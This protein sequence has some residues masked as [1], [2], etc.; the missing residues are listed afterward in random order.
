[1]TGDDLVWFMKH[2]DRQ[3]RVREAIDDERLPC[4]PGVR[5]L[6]VVGRTGAAHRF[7]ASPS[8]CCPSS[9]FGLLK[10]V[11]EIM[12]HASGR[13]RKDFAAGAF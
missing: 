5:T 10:L 6:V 1:M 12:P 3:L 7:Q 13:P 2:M 8:F 11:S 9:D 4:Q